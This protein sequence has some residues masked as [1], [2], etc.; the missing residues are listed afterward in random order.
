[1]AVPNFKKELVNTVSFP[2]E[3]WNRKL[4]GM[5]LGVKVGPDDNFILKDK[6]KI[7]K[8]AYLANCSTDYLYQVTTDKGKAPEVDDLAFGEYFYS[9]PDGMHFDEAYGIPKRIFDAI[10]EHK[11]GMPKEVL[12]AID[13]MY[14]CIKYKDYS[15]LPEVYSSYKQSKDFDAKLLAKIFTMVDQLHD[16]DSLYKISNY[17]NHIATVK[18][19]KDIVQNGI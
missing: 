3:G 2:F 14:A 19:V 11:I 4:L 10:I 1:M 12:T 13:T 16:V 15:F 5:I 6:A 8:L 9:K 18:I 17:C 7:K